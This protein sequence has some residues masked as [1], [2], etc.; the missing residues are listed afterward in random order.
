[1]NILDSKRAYRIRPTSDEHECRTF[2]SGFPLGHMKREGGG[3]RAVIDAL[4]T[5]PYPQRNNLVAEAFGSFAFISVEAEHIDLLV[6]FSHP[7]LFVNVGGDKVNVCDDLAT[8]AVFTGTVEPN[9]IEVLRYLPGTINGHC[10]TSP[11]AGISRIPGGTSGRI[12]RSG[13]IRLAPVPLP[14]TAGEDL[15]NLLERF[16]LLLAKQEGHTCIYSSGGIDS[17]ALLAIASQSSRPIYTANGPENSYRQEVAAMVMAAVCGAESPIID[18]DDHDIEDYVGTLNDGRPNETG[19]MPKPDH[20]ALFE[21]RYDLLIKT[22]YFRDSYKVRSADDRIAGSGVAFTTRVNGYG[23][24]ELLLGEK[25][26]NSLSSIYACNVLWNFKNVLERNPFSLGNVSK[27]FASILIRHRLGKHSPGLTDLIALEI[28]DHYAFFGKASDA[29]GSGRFK[30]VLH[31]HVSAQALDLARWIARN[32]LDKGGFSLSSYVL[33]IRQFLYFNVTH[34]HVLRYASHGQAQ[35]SIYEFPYV[36]GPIVASMA[37]SLPRVLHDW[38]PKRQLFRIFGK[39][40]GLNY[41]RGLRDAGGRASGG[42]KWCAGQDCLG[43]VIRLVVRGSGYRTIRAVRPARGGRSVGLD[44]AASEE[45]I[46]WHRV[47]EALTAAFDGS[48]CGD[49]LSGMA[50]QPTDGLQHAALQV[51]QSVESDF[52]VQAGRVSTSPKLGFSLTHTLNWMHIN[53]FFDSISLRRSRFGT[54]QSC[55]EINSWSV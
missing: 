34:L 29:A 42:A 10:F 50:T 17:A 39:R 32:S 14:D 25:R 8:L 16:F 24:D 43:S 15:E 55:S 47:D 38:H 48:L 4:I 9:P 37:S 53:L 28:C 6:S 7:G 19:P 44:A 23:A 51:L 21:Q 26:D 12:S 3:P 33:M 1:M 35:G 13:E 54:R 30:D 36:Q 49:T 31:D 5:T 52:R 20:Q 45:R 40:T 2:I 22:N 11:V 41:R 18:V 27:Q 46:H